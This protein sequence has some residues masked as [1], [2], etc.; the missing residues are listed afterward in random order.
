MRAACRG[1]QR[2]CAE[3]AEG[4][5]L[6]TAQLDA[7]AGLEPEGRS[8]PRRVADREGFGFLPSR[9][10]LPR[11]VGSPG[12]GEQ[13]SGPPSVFRRACRINVLLLAV[14]AA[15]HV[16]FDGVG[17]DP[18]SCE[19]TRDLCARGDQRSLIGDRADSCCSDAGGHAAERQ[20]RGVERGRRSRGGPACWCGG[21]ESLAGGSAVSPRRRDSSLAYDSTL[22]RGRGS[23]Q[24]PEGIGD[25][26]LMPLLI[27]RSPPCRRRFLFLRLAPCRRPPKSFAVRA[28]WEFSARMP[29]DRSRR[30]LAA[31]SRK[32]LRPRRWT[33]R[34]QSGKRLSA[35]GRAR[36]SRTRARS[37]RRR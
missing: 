32:R 10:T 11:R 36:R 25:T 18:S 7:C 33:R 5:S 8:A 17:D 19:A 20:V 35:A 28:N 9:L 2:R 37:A 6:S 4:L 14:A 21:A 1:R 30:P 15:P 13:R 23:F 34:R 16:R 31:G 24:P 27:S 22:L 26:G 12:G 3:R 29:R